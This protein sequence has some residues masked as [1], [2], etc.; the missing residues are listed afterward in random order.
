MTDVTPATIRATVAARVRQQ[1]TEQ[2]LSQSDLA[3]RVW[4]N[5]AKAPVSH[6]ENMNNGANVNNRRGVYAYT[7]VR[8]AYALGVNPCW[9]MG[10]DDE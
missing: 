6:I 1:R 10:V 7:V 8:L 4:G 9:L 2:A 3:Q 5:R